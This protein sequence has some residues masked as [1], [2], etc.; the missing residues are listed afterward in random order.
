MAKITWTFT[1]ESGDNLN[2]YIA[3][4]VTTGEKI[5]FDLLRGGTIKVAGTP[6]NKATLDKLITAINEAYD[7]IGVNESGIATNKT[8][9]STNATNISTNKTNIATNTSDISTLKTSVS[10]NTSNISSNTTNI[11][12]LTKTVGTNATNIGKNSTDISTLKT[13]VSTNTSDISTLKTSVSTNTSDI[14][15]IENGTT[16]VEKA[17]NDDEGSTLKKYRH[18]ITINTSDSSF[19]GAVN[20]ETAQIHFTIYNS[21][22]NAMTTI[23]SILNNQKDN[24][25]FPAFFTGMYGYGHGCCIRTGGSLYFSIRRTKDTSSGGTAVKDIYFS[26]STSTTFTDSVTKI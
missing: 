16:V 22:K 13:S 20:N 24:E 23:S 6:L 18:I 21:N 8:A 11:S 15:N 19:L 10:T 12:N 9:I 5:T 4:N 26:P 7:K 2:R 25:S 14:A 1:D 17:K 3:T